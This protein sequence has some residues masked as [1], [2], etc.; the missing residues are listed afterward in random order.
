MAVILGSRGLAP[1][2]AQAHVD[3]GCSQGLADGFQRVALGPQLGDVDLESPGLAAEAAGR[4]RW[5]EAHHRHLAAQ[6]GQQGEDRRG[7]GESLALPCRSL[8]RF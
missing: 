7:R 1:D 4:M 6:R 2:G 8:V 3:A 5:E